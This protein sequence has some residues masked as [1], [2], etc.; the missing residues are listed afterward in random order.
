[1][2]RFLKECDILIRI[3]DI[4]DH[5]DNSSIQ[6]G[7]WTQIV[8]HRF[9]CDTQA[10]FPNGPQLS[11]NGAQL[12][13]TQEC[14]LG[15]HRQKFSMAQ[16]SKVYHRLICFCVIVSIIVCLGMYVPV[17]VLHIMLNK[18]LCLYWSPVCMPLNVNCRIETFQNRH[19]PGRCRFLHLQIPITCLASQSLR[20]LDTV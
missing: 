3:N 7:D 2:K 19:P 5:F 16:L 10:P 9:V 13:P 6:N 8:S 1:M 12:G 15:S 11:P 14:C 20:H 17:I 18:G 4:S